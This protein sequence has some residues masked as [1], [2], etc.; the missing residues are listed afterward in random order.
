M[1]TRI[2]LG[3]LEAVLERIICFKSRRNVKSGGKSIKLPGSHS[4]VTLKSPK[5]SNPTL[6][7]NQEKERYEILALRMHSTSG[8]VGGYRINGLLAISNE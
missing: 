6:N 7:F 3:F 5:P 8:R 2:V 4:S 1:D